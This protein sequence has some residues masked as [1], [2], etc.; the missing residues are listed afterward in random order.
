MKRRL[1]LALYLPRR[2]RHARSRN[3]RLGATVT[4]LVA[5][6]A[7]VRWDLQ[8]ARADRHRAVHLLADRHARVADLHHELLHVRSQLQAVETVNA[9]LQQAFNALTKDR[10]A[11]PT[12]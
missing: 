10:T 3:A 11:V 8:L 12:P 7:R 5:T 6:V 9:E 2:L 4:V 1:I